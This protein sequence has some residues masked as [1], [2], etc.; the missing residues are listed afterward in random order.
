MKYLKF[1]ALMIV[2]IWSCSVWYKGAE[3]SKSSAYEEGLTDASWQTNY[4]EKNMLSQ[5][6]S[7]GFWQWEA[8]GRLYLIDLIISDPEFTDL[9]NR[10]NLDGVSLSNVVSRLIALQLQAYGMATTLTAPRIVFTP[11]KGEAN[12]LY[13]PQDKSIYLNAKMHWNGLSFERLVEVVF[14][15]N[16]HHILSHQYPSLPSDHKLYDDFRLLTWAAF[17]PD[18]LA[19]ENAV[20]DEAYLNPQEKV[21]YQSQRA[22]RYAGIIGSNLSAW[23]MTARTQEI[24]VIQEQANISE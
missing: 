14:H 22:A 1:I 15:E 3:K 8:Q 6:L 7:P 24:R 11:L 9:R 17:R 16:M 5:S 4:A 13:S 19:N 23:E 20:P 18:M 10:E 21:A 12:G 2:T